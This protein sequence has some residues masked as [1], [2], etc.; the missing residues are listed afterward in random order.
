MNQRG[1]YHSLKIKNA[2]PED[3]GEYTFKVGCKSTSAKVTVDA[4][5]VTKAITDKKIKE[6]RRAV[7]ECELSVADGGMC[8]WIKDGKEII[9][10]R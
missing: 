4:V 5:C 6:T 8:R 3:T 1:A 10:S 9:V 7:L 2:Q